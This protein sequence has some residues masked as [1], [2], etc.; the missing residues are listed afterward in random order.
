MVRLRD[1]GAVR[2]VQ[3]AYRWVAEHRGELEES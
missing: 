3:A 1:V 2:E